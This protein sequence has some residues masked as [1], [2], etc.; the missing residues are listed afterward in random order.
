MTPYVIFKV[1]R[2]VIFPPFWIVY[3]ITRQTTSPEV[4]GGLVD[5]MHVDDKEAILLY[6]ESFIALPSDERNTLIGSFHF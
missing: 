2:F 3:V 1:L 6:L 4:M 5:L